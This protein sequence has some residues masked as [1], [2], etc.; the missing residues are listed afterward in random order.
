M[1]ASSA[2]IGYNSTFAIGDG[3]DPTETFTAVAEVTNI[4]PPGYS[5]DAIDVTHMK[6]DDQFRE[7]I[8]GLMD[9]GEVQIELNYVPSA[10][11][12]LIAALTGGK[13]NFQITLPNSITFTFAAICTAYTP[14]VPN[15]DKL[16]ASATFK[17]SGKPTLA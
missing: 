11:D 14:A 7:Y 4:T 6:S 15:D 10:S 12:V 3:G 8:A 13:G 2:I 5:R 1:A 17:V 9:A 16:S